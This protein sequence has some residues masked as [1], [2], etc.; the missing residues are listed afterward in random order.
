[1][2]P[3]QKSLTKSSIHDRTYLFDWSLL[4]LYFV[5]DLVDCVFIFWRDSNFLK[6]QV[7][8]VDNVV[9]VASCL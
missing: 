3:V 6:Q 4:P 2:R 5:R 7:W 9:H 1:M 8:E